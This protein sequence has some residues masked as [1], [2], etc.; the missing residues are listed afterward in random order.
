MSTNLGRKDRSTHVDNVNSWRGKQQHHGAQPGYHGYHSPP[1]EIPSFR[2]KQEPAIL[3]SE[4]Q[5]RF[6]ERVT[7]LRTKLEALKAAKMLKSDEAVVDKTADA[8]PIDAGNYQDVN[9]IYESIISSSELSA[10][11]SQERFAAPI[12]QTLGI[13]PVFIMSHPTPKESDR[14]PG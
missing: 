3:D 13:A 9:T 6:M 1:L 5:D 14:Y 8:A 12:L 10:N 2:K 4:A 11:S 7:T